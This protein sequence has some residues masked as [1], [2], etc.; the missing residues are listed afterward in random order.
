LISEGT[1][2]LLTYY[3]LI[4]FGALAGGLPN[5]RKDFGASLSS[6]NIAA[7]KDSAEKWNSAKNEVN[8]V[9]KDESVWKWGG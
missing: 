1:I 2:T 7:K 3:Y 6:S 5:F 4:R 8:A 9:N